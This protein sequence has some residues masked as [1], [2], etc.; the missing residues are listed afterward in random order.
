MCKKVPT[1][2]TDIEISVLK[3]SP[4]TTQR[5]CCAMLKLQ[6]GHFYDT[7]LNIGC[8][9]DTTHFSKGCMLTHQAQPA[10][11]MLKKCCDIFS[12]LPQPTVPSG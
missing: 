3:M 6:K 9:I 1:K 10:E 5:K 2:N 7:F 8:N 11:V 4:I 12:T